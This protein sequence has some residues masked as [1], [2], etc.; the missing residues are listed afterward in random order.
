M[1][2]AQRFVDSRLRQGAPREAVLQELVQRGWHVAQAGALIDS[3]AGPAPQAPTFAPPGAPGA[4]GAAIPPMFAQPSAPPTIQPAAQPGAQTF[5][6]PAVQPTIQPAA[7][8]GTP[9]FPQNGAHP[10][11]PG[12]PGATPSAGP[13]RASVGITIAVVLLSINVAATVVT[14]VWPFLTPLGPRDV[15]ERIPQPVIPYL[16]I[17]IPLWVAALVL[18]L[19][20]GSAAK[21]QPGSGPR[22]RRGAAV[23]LLVIAPVLSAIVL[24]GGGFLYLALGIM[25]GEAVSANCGL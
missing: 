17:A 6:Q 19:V 18:V 20:A 4:P 11:A 21:A 5:A 7:Q 8:P 25:C 3:V 16:L 23:S 13:S 12:A 9:T 1:D 10:G 2:E 15:V 22:P 24:V 14:A